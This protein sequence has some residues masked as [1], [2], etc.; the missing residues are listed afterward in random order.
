MR[1]HARVLLLAAS[2]MVIAG[3]ASNA[4]WNYQ[5]NAPQLTAA[6]VPLTVAV[7]RF[8]DQRG[9]ENSTYMWL[10]IIPL[11]PYCTAA[12]ERPD[13]ANRFLTAG[14]Y[15]FRPD[16]DLSN[17]A[18]LEL[19]QDGIF[20]EVFVTGRTMDPAA[21]LILR[22]TIINTN[23]N[24]T[25]Y[26]YLLGPYASLLWLFGAPIGT[27]DNTLN[28]RLELVQQSNAAV[29]WSDEISQRYSK[30]EGIYY[31]YSMDFGYP[32]M[33]REGMKQAVASLEQYVSSQPQSF[34]QAM[35]P[36]AVVNSAR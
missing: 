22:G 9:S 36:T 1:E 6:H 20:R 34:W 17:A 30:T 13:T 12:Y 11:V 3:C 33:F 32:R 27:A 29:L 28:V 2:V 31:N 35:M 19:K 7:E 25:G 14:A 10:C 8:K 21:Q 26:S 23:W 24:G 4:G 15:N 5:P 18:A 16:A